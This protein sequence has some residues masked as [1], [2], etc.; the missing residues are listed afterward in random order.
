MKNKKGT[1]IKDIRREGKNTSVC[2]ES[3][4]ICSI[5]VRASTYVQSR[6]ALFLLKVSIIF[7]LLCSSFL[8][9]LTLVS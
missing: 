8:H 7:L 3:K 9:L 5:I 4:S 6:I 1:G 2:D